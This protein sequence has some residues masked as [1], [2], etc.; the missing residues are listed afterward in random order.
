MPY[1]TLK[2]N[3]SRENPTAFTRENM[4]EFEME[5]F[6]PNNSHFLG[7]RYGQALNNVFNF[8]TLYSEKL[9]YEENDGYSRNIAWFKFQEIEDGTKN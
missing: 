7:L 6:N 3:G 1:I 5:F 2:G 8:D 4:V 9:F